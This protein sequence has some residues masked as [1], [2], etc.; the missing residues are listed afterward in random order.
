M[1]FNVALL[2]I[3]PVISMMLL[4]PMIQ[5]DKVNKTGLPCMLSWQVLEHLVTIHDTHKSTFANTYTNLLIDRIRCLFFVF[6]SNQ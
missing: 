1:Y 4:S 3:H 5:G 6:F 2:I